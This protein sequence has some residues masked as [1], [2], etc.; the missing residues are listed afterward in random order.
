MGLEENAFMHTTAYTETFVV[1]LDSLIWYAYQSMPYQLNTPPTSFL[2]KLVGCWRHLTH[3]E[4]VTQES[5]VIP[6]PPSWK[7]GQPQLVLLTGVTDLQFS[8]FA[9]C[10]LRWYGLV[11]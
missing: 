2:I 1:V 8:V 10:S 4:L 9:L 6:D 11:G 3:A 5:G 7:L